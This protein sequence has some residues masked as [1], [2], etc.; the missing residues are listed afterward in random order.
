M[1]ECFHFVFDE[2]IDLRIRLK[3]LQQTRSF[4]IFS[5][6]SCINEKFDVVIS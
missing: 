4:V 5:M 1:I 3:I 6:H 2:Y